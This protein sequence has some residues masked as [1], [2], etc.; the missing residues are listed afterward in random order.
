MSTVGNAKR[1][2]RNQTRGRPRMSELILTERP[3]PGVLLIRL[4]RPD[5]LN[6]MNAPLVEALHAVLA[7]VRHDSETRAIVLT[8]N[9]RA[10]CA[11]ID[12]RGYGTPPGATEGEGRA[13]AGMRVQQHIAS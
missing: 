3:R 5:A 10:F 4:N 7:D 8:G 12:L 6:A 13:Q 11:G 9:G 1:S 2:R